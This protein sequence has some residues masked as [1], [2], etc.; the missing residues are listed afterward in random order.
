MTFEPGAPTTYAAVVAG[1]G[2]TVWATSVQF[3]LGI[4]VGVLTIALLLVRLWVDVPRALRKR[5]GL[6]R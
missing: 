2:V 3:W 1:S 6:G 4:T 5:K